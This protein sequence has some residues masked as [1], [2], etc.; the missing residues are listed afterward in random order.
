MCEEQSGREA[1]GTKNM[2][3]MVSNVSSRRSKMMAE[4]RALKRMRHLSGGGREEANVRDGCGKG[5]NTRAERRREGRRRGGDDRSAIYSP[6]SS[7]KKFLHTKG[8]TFSK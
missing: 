7:G 4:M 2:A 5:E 1:S 3:K 8:L 6:I